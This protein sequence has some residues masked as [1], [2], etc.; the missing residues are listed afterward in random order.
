MTLHF[1]L[2]KSTL[3]PALHRGRIPMRDAID[4]DGTIGPV[5]TVGRPGMIMLYTCVDCICF[6]S[7]KL[8]CTGELVTSL[9]SMSAPSMMKMEVAPV[10]AITWFVMIMRAF[11][12]C[13]TGVPNNAQAIA[14][15]EEGG[16]C[17]G[18][19]CVWFD[20]TTVAVSSLQDEDQLTE[21]GSKRNEV[22]ENEWLHLWVNDRISAPHH[23]MF[24]FAGRTVLCIPF[25]HG[26]YP[27]AMNCW[28]FAQVYP[29]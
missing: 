18:N 2:S 23:Q 20:M 4:S 12:Y 3:H 25:V 9:L 10:S 29:A 19:C 28:A 13:S 17:G 15:I 14:T 11:K 7:G 5:N 1:V 27:A 22:A 8:L 26:S 24:R 21:V 6:P 16:F